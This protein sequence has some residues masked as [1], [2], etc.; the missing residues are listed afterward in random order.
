MYNFL[1]SRSL[2][3]SQTWLLPKWNERCSF[4]QFRNICVSHQSRLHP[5]VVHN[6]SLRGKVCVAYHFGYI[7]TQICQVIWKHLLSVRE[8]LLYKYE[9]STVE[10]LQTRLH[11][12]KAHKGLQFVNQ[13][14]CLLREWDIFGRETSLSKMFCLFCQLVP[15]QQRDMLPGKQV[16]FL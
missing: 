13:L 15:I 9:Q 2:P 11:K 8:V 6:P 5:V 12:K 7:V 1:N 10:T 4:I 3:E 16:F 14:K